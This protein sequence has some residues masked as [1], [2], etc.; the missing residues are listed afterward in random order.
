VDAIWPTPRE[1]ER[2]TI[3]LDLPPEERYREVVTDRLARYGWEGTYQPVVDYYDDLVPLALQPLFD[4]ISLNLDRYFPTEYVREINGLYALVREN[5]YGDQLTLS[6][7]VGM[8]MIYEWTSACTSIVAED[9]QGVMWHGRN[10][11]WSFDGYSLYNISM[12]ADYKAGGV[13]QYSGVSWAGYVGLLTGLN[14]AFSITVDQRDQNYPAGVPD[15]VEAIKNG[16]QLVAFFVR[17]VL[18]NNKTFSD[19]VNAL[20]NVPVAAPVY[21]IVGGA[22]TDQGAVVTRDRTKAVDVWKYGVPDVRC[23]DWYL[24]E[25]NYDHWLPDNTKD[26]RQTQAIAALN[27]MTRANLNADNLFND[28]LKIPNVLNNGTQYSIVINL[29]Q[30]YSHAYGWQ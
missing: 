14:S 21:L 1:I 8:N 9:T 25:T 16:S 30:N 26:P 11:D 5:G 27:T 10:L 4:D 7:I 22:Q 13:T 15:N 17:E 28:V 23:A 3:N 18:T 6:M 20:A 29:K 12:F 24:V 2:V 19:A